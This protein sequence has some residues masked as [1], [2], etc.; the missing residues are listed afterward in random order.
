LQKLADGAHGPVLQL[1]KKQNRE[2][3][4]ASVGRGKPW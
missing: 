3:P 2:L 1:F 4:Y